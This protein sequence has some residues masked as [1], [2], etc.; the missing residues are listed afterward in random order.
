MTDATGRL[1]TDNSVTSKVLEVIRAAERQLALVSPYIDEV[2]H[3]QQELILAKT[4]GVKIVV[5]VRRDSSTVG[6]NNSE[7]ALTWFA[8]HG[9]EVQSVPNLHAKFYMNEREG[10]LTSMNLLRSSWSGSM[11]VG[12]IVTGEEH[13][14]LVEYLTKHLKNFFSVVTPPSS[15][16][17]QKSS[18]RRP[19]KS[20]GRKQSGGIGA[21]IKNLITAPSGYCIRCGDLLSAKE[22]DSGKVLCAAD[23]R[24]WAK[25]KNAD[26]ME[27]YCTTCGSEWDTSYAKPECSD[28]YFA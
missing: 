3:V 11:E 14:Q 8:D 21:M 25:Y 16:G 1:L 10:V 23:Y 9:I 5:V 20:N 4:R 19:A 2:G 28:C 6:G 17:K 13:R 24:S 7:S 27:N 22:I 26:F 12:V 18:V 15:T